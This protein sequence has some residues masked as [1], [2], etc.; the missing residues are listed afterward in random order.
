MKIALKKKLYKRI[1]IKSTRI[2]ILCDVLINEESRKISQL[3]QKGNQEPHMYCRA[4]MLRGCVN[5]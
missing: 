1:N 4:G 3:V 2:K 5:G